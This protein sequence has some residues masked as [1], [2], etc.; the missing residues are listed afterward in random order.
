MSGTKHPW[1]G[2]L[3]L[4]NDGGA[5][6]HIHSRSGEHIATV[7]YIQDRDSLR[8]TEREKRIADLIKGAPELLEALRDMLEGYCARCNY[9]KGNEK[10]CC[11]LP[12][13][14]RA[15]AARA[16]IIAVEGEPS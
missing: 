1:Y 5:L 9:C 8:A 4:H 3:P 12:G 11:Q 14:C 6:Q 10:N 7:A 15:P 13:A 16:A 2:D